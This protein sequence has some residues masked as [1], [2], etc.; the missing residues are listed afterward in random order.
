MLSMWNSAHHKSHEGTSTS[1]HVVL[2]SAMEGRWHRSGIYGPHSRTVSP[3]SDLL[4]KAARLALLQDSGRCRMP[5]HRHTT[6]HSDRADS[7]IHQC[8]LHTVHLEQKDTEGKMPWGSLPNCPRGVTAKERS[9][10][11]VSFI[12]CLL[13]ILTVRK[14]TVLVLYKTRNYKNIHFSV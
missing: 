14:K 13:L 1:G 10:A 9:D 4:P 8:S 5:S 2:L 12:Y 6:L 7:R 11:S 3:D